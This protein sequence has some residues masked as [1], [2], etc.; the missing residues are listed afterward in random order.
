MPLIAILLVLS[1]GAAAGDLVN[2]HVH[3][4]NN[5]GRVDIHIHNIVH[6]PQLLSDNTLM[7]EVAP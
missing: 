5:A 6:N 7:F 3:G 1:A 2:V 4:L